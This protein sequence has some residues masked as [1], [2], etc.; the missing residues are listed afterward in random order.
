MKV[1]PRCVADRTRSWFSTRTRGRYIPEE[2]VACGREA[3]SDVKP[4]PDH[5]RNRVRQA[6]E[7]RIFLRGDDDRMSATTLKTN[8][9]QPEQ[10]S[11]AVLELVPK[12]F[13]ADLIVTPADNHTPARLTELVDS[14]RQHGQLVPGWIAPSPE[15][16]QDQRLCLEGNCRLAAA[17][18]LGRRFW[19]F[20]LGR[21][22]PEEERIRLMFQ[23][24][25]T[26]RRWSREE[27]AERAAR[28]IELTGCTAA[29]AARHLNVS[30]ATLSRAFGERRIPPELK[31]RTDGLL[32]SIR[33]L[34]AAAPQAYMAQ[35]VEFAETPGRTRDQ[36]AAFIQ[37][38]KKRKSLAKGRKAKT[39][40]LRL[41]GRVVTLTVG[42]RDSAASV[43]ED[44]KAI[45]ARLGKHADV[46]PDGWHFLFQ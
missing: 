32:L 18:M 42:D 26:R 36:V 5:D 43:A 23:H 14:I 4:K 41:G 25:G 38:L 44:L 45:V 33:P 2:K 22:V 11:P 9:P 13:D 35:A 6:R 17:R 7:G 10:P 3:V 34:I 28:Y 19:A 40:A 24:H 37:Q 39:V 29:E 30:A 12:Y 27:I 15:L 8:S 21:H 20:D 46:P 31:P 16:E 1:R